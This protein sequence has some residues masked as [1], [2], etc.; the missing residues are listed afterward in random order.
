MIAR[1]VALVFGLSFALPLAAQDVY[2][3]GEVH[4]NPAHHAVQAERVAEIRPSAIVF[5]ML[6]AA[7]ARKVVPELRGDQ[8]ALAEALE[9]GESGWPDF[10]LYYPIFAAAP[11]AAI[12][13]AQ[14]PREE[15]RA[16]FEEGLAASFGA[17]AVRY[18]LDRPLPATEQTEREALQMAAHCDAL[19]V[20]ILPGMVDIQR[21]RD[22]ALARAVLN[23]LDETGGPVAVITGNGHA[24]RDWGVPAVL[25]A[26]RDG[27]G[28]AVLGQTEDGAPLEGGFDEV[29]SAEAV[30]RPDP[31]AA[32]K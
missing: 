22:T 12:Y 11:E 9:W 31:C 1:Y 13:G 26:A 3:L 8:A 15:A 18:G 14:V 28:I 17:D 5:E 30:D 2:V 27:L 20:D 23:A 32:F 4:D 7:Q 24:R 16:V 29:I 10:A 21:L 6:T 19:P 25:S